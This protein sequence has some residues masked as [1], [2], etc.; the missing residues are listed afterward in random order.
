MLLVPLQARSS[1]SAPC[2]ARF[3]CSRV[4]GRPQN[5]RRRSRGTC[6]FSRARAS[7]VSRGRWY[8]AGARSPTLMS[9]A[10]WTAAARRAGAPSIADGVCAR[11]AVSASPTTARGSVRPRGCVASR[12]VGTMSSGAPSTRASSRL[13][14]GHH[15]S[16]HLTPHHQRHALQF[17]RGS[18]RHD[19]RRSGRGRELED[20]PRH[21]TDGRDL[22]RSRRSISRPSWGP[23]AA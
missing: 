5:P 23:S 20:R 13:R 22:R 8:R 9:V 18:R 11:T 7:R 12:G 14:K 15:G 21:G 6:R 2:R 4:A 10:V 3:S 17:V 1:R 19:P 16:D